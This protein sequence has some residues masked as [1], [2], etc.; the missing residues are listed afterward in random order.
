MGKK[1]PRGKR[2]IPDH[3]WLRVLAGKN[4]RDIR[5]SQKVSAAQLARE[6][7]ID[8]RTVNRIEKGDVGTT[9]DSLGHIADKLHLRDYSK[10]FAT[11]SDMPALTGAGDLH[12]RQGSLKIAQRIKGRR[13]KKD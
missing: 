8:R 13:D 12:F 3:D 2:N 10:L 1:T 11:R 6:V 7:G 4:I 9:L 5:K